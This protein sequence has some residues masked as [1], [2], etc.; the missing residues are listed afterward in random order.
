MI[1][2]CVTSKKIQTYRYVELREQLAKSMWWK[3]MNV[4]A[5]TETDELF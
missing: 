1:Q 5:T 3:L 4:M 2:S